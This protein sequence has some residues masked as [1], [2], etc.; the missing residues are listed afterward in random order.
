MLVVD[1]ANSTLDFECATPHSLLYLANMNEKN[2]YS[3]S[4][5]KR[6]AKNNFTRLIPSDFGWSNDKFKYWRIE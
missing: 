3:Y 1:N 2:G 4:V 5:S 6:D